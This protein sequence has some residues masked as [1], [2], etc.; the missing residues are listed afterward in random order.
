MSAVN[1][2]T[3][4]KTFPV[5]VN[6]YFIKRMNKN[7]AK[8][9]LLLPAGTFQRLKIALAYGAD[10]VYVGMPS[11]SLR[12]T[13][14][15]TQDELAEGARLMH[16]A[17][18]K[19]YVALNLFSKNADIEKLPAI[20]ARLREIAPDGVIVSDPAIFMFLREHA[21][22]IPLHISTQANIS[23][24]A[25]VEFWQK[26][27]A[28]L[29]VLS[30]ETSFDEI[31]EIRRRVPAMKLEMFI[32]GAMCM[33][34]SGR[35]LLSAFMTGRSANQGKCAQSCRWGYKVFLEEEKRPGE[36]IAVEEDSRGTYFMNSRDLCLLP[37]LPKIL[38]A[39]IASLKIEGRN[40]SDYY[41]AQ[42]ARVY[43]AAIDAWFENPESWNAEPYM[44]ELEMLQNRTYTRGFFSG[45]PGAEAQNYESTVSI[46]KAQNVGMVVENSPWTQA[47]GTPAGDFVH[48]EIRNK[49]SFGDEIDF[50]I[51]GQFNP[52]KISVA[53]MVDGFT[54]K[55]A[56]SISAGRAGQT[57]MFPRRLFSENFV[58][59]LTMVRKCF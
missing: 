35:C 32:H 50:L 16:A 44:R 37:E 43:R 31:C 22:E 9:E 30:R 45:V 23:S 21:P 55:P 39:G 51:P 33:S 29:C 58:P 19:I 17:G 27:G 10:A 26:L 49:I 52:L 34:Y 40:K 18:K 24:W 53:E 47:T 48:V 13:V 54:G 8:P 6:W 59:A 5:P 20:A 12:A 41:V 46:G 57:V 28:E 4:R 1:A 2:G 42:T 56:E 15:L 36:L 7:L 38:Q 25:T 14:G 3:Q 11:M